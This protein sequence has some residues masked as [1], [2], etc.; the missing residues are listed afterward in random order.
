[1]IAKSSED[2]FLVLGISN[3]VMFDDVWSVTILVAKMGKV[4]NEGEEFA[5]KLKIQ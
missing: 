5:A 2:K 3:T 1:M 4:E